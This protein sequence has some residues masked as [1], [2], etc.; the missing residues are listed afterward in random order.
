MTS[1][2]TKAILA[3]AIGRSYT[4]PFS[5][6]LPFLYV[7]EVAGAFLAAVA[8]DR[9]GARILDLNGRTATTAR[10]RDLVLQ[11]FPGA[12]IELGAAPFPFPANLSDAPAQALLGDYGVTALEDGVRETAANV[13]RA[14]E[15]GAGGSAPAQ[16]VMSALG[17]Q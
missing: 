3:A 11:E 8:E 17:S 9:E 13:P 4:I 15:G 2:P 1:A 16:G 5:G 10:F 7:R 6:E 12:D 14:D